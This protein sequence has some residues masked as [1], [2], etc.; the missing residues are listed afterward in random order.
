MNTRPK[1]LMFA[2]AVDSKDVGEAQLTYQWIEQIAQ[3]VDVTLIT[4]GSRIHKKCGFENHSSVRLKIVKPLLRFRWAGAFDRVFKP[5]YV[6]LYRR[7]RV[8]AKE[9]LSAES[10]DAL[11]H[12]APHS[13]RYPS[14]LHGLHKRFYIGPIHGGLGLPEAF[15]KQNIK[16]KIAANIRRID[17]WRYEYDGLINKHFH[18][19]NKL[20]IS[21][22]YVKD[23]LP[24]KFSDK[25][26]VI[27]PQ[28]P[29]TVEC[30]LDRKKI[31]KPLKLLFVGRLIENKGVRYAIEALKELPQDSYHFTIY[32]TGDL[33]VELKKLVD[34][35]NLSRCVT[36]KGF[37]DHKTILSEMPKH[38]V[39]LFPSLKEAWGLV[40]T[41]AMNSGL[42]VVCADRGGP[43]YI[44]DETCGIKL[45]AEN[46]TVLV[47]EMYSAIQ[48]LIAD[49]ALVHEMGKGARRKVDREFTWD[50][51]T[52]KMLDLYCCSD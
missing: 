20:L 45:S 22:P 19:A 46:P 35:Y 39:L 4:M 3:K 1:V 31:C 16:T 11:H 33:E 40:V 10:F 42:A 24:A 6:E 32:G 51:L 49:H 27:P 36:F 12:I 9:I 15:V 28:P 29:A 47:R 44:V 43:G 14:P 52:Q 50:V 48:K 13:P 2:Y 5:D 18:S 26:L 25:C 37:A 30:D 23:L 34:E 38:D 17:G 21:A 7:A 41:E 8:L